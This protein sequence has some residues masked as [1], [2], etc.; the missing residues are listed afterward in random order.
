MAPKNPF[1]Q[2][3]SN[4]HGIALPMCFRESAQIVKGCIRAELTVENQSTQP[5]IVVCPK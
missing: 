1:S 3:V 5:K 4:F 2:T